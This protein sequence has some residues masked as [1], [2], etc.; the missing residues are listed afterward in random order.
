MIT[1]LAITPLQE[2]PELIRKLGTLK[3]TPMQRRLLFLLQSQDSIFVDDLLMGT[4]GG[5]LYDLLYESW[6]SHDGIRQRNGFNLIACI[7][8]CERTQGVTIRFSI[9]RG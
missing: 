3:E 6:N 2:N 7:W 4:K 8:K 9:R 1:I 5:E